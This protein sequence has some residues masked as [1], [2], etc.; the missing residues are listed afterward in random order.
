MIRVLTV[1]GTRPEAIKLAPV[2]KWLQ[3]WTEEFESIV[4]VTAQHRQMLD[5]VM[6]AFGIYANFDLDLMRDNQS[7]ASVAAAVLAE[8]PGVL[9]SSRPD[10]VLVQGDTITTFSASLA[11]YLNHIPVAHVEAGLRTGDFEH[12]FPE[13]MNRCLTSRV[14]ALHFAPTETARKALLDDNID[15]ESIFRAVVR[16][17][18]D[19]ETR[20]SRQRAALR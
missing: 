18:R 9:S 12:P 4:C 20:L 2:V 10:V 11:A 1:F 5:Q 15:P 19:R 13:E 6:A 3:Q 7:P 16:F 8:L 14:A 17:A